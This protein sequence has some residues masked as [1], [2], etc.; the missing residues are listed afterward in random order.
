M[1]I[2]LKLH[3]TIDENYNKNLGENAYLKYA[4]SEINWRRVFEIIGFRIT[5]LY[6]NNP[7]Y[8]S[9]DHIEYIF[10]RLKDLYEGDYSKIIEYDVTEDITYLPKDI[11][12]LK[13]DIES[14]YFLFTEYVDKKCIINVY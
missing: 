12:S 2:D 5:I 4:W 3:S 11:L 8:W 7:S 13:K 9:V 1:G 6:D 10:L 14:L